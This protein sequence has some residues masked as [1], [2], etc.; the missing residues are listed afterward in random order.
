[1]PPRG[2]NPEVL[3]AHDR[4]NH[5]EV[6]GTRPLLAR[7]GSQGASSSEVGSAVQPEVVRRPAAD[8]ANHAEPAVVEVLDRFEAGP[9]KVEPL[10]AAR[11]YALTGILAFDELPNGPSGTSNVTFFEGNYTSYMAKRRR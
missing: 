2:V 9:L 8:E 6:E 10:L 4:C 1:M 5:Q 7:S 11:S 3:G